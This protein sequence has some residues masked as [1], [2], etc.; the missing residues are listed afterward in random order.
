MGLPEFTAYQQQFR[1]G[2]AALPNITAE[3]NA[4]SA[5]EKSAWSK[6]RNAERK[7]RD[8]VAAQQWDADIAR[9]DLN[10]DYNA[11][12]IVINTVADY[13]QFQERVDSVQNQYDD[14][15][16]E[17]DRWAEL[18][19]DLH[20]AESAHA[21]AYAPSLAF[22]LRER[23]R[24]L[25]WIDR[26]EDQ[27]RLLNS[28]LETP[29]VA[30]DP[31]GRPRMPEHWLPRRRRWQILQARNVQRARDGH[32]PGLVGSD[33]QTWRVGATFGGGQSYG[34]L[35]LQFDDRTDTIVDVSQS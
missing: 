1:H 13:E 15:K 25:Q 14:L 35:W 11:D 16:P 5:A 24:K 27:M 2:P 32:R 3:W 31:Q 4:K 23:S 9:N 22:A 19:Q 7:Q 29:P 10:N 20:D 33:N 18:W 34:T 8:K 28:L 21:N 6:A 12:V 26:C 30:Q 17:Y